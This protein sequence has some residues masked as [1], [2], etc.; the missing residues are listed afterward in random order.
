MNGTQFMVTAYIVGLGLVLGYALV[1][2][3]EWHRLH[4]HHKGK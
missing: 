4:R 2:F 3:L 1:L